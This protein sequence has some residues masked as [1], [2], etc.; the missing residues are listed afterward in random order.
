MEFFHIGFLAFL[1]NTV[2]LPST[3]PAPPPPPQPRCPQTETT[4]EF[5][6]AETIVSYGQYSVFRSKS[7]FLSS[8]RNI[9]RDTPRGVRSLAFELRLRFGNEP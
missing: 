7:L 6:T 5:G 4:E 9:Y 3:N 8:V 1:I 2:V